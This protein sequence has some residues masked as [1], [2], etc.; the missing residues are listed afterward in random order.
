[1]YPNT[2]PKCDSSDKES[3]HEKHE[4]ILDTEFDSS[5]ENLIKKLVKV[6]ISLNVHMINKH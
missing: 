2:T 4:K 5:F 1:M 3:F 6:I